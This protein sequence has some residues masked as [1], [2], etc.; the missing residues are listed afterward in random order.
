MI[1]HILSLTPVNKLM[2]TNDNFRLQV[3]AACAAE[4]R[5]TGRPE[6]ALLFSGAR[7]ITLYKKLMHLM[8]YNY[9]FIIRE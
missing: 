6:T 7:S 3:R 5:N 8:S 1:V 2:F 9:C 4:D